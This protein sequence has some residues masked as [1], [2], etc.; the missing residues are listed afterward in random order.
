MIPWEAKLTLIFRTVTALHH[1]SYF[2][3]E[4]IVL[5]FLDR[6]KFHIDART[7][8]GTTPIIKAACARPA[9]HP[10]VVK[11]LLQRGADPC[12]GNWYGNALHC[13]AEAGCSTVV[14]QLIDYGMNPNDTK[15]YDRLPI[16]CTLDN[17]RSSAFET[18][19]ELGADINL[20]VFH[21][22]IKYGCFNVVDL[23][24]QRHW[25]Q[26]ESKTTSG[27]AAMHFAAE[28]G[29][30]AIISRL[31]EAGADI[32]ILDSKGKTPLDYV[33]RNFNEDVAMYMLSH[34]AVRGISKDMA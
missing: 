26:L 22:A 16:Y 14:R 20:S 4:N 30:M 27:I 1:A 5:N 18:L 31:L 29:D 23:I 9:G 21:K 11:M 12:L 24:L 17:D 32:N 6:E 10:S 25:T 19:V 34:G 8:M 3:L 13:A 15:H 28:E 33:G 7:K 2:G